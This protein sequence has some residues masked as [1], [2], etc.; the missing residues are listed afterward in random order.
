VL[1]HTVA[2]V[3]AEVARTPARTAKVAQLATLLSS[4]DQP[5]VLVAWLSGDLTQRQIGVGWATL[6]D[7]PEPAG[8]ASV[9]I[10]EVEAAFNAIKEVSGP[11]SQTARREVIESLF[12]RATEV[13]QRFLR[14]LLSG[15]L[16]QGAL[17]GVVMAAI[18]KAS[19]VSLAELRRAAMLRGDLPAVAAAALS[20]GSRALR[21]FRLQVGRAIGPM[22]AQTA[23]DPAEAL[24]KLGG[25]AAFEWKLDGARVQLHRDGD[26]A[27]AEHCRH[28]PG[29]T[30]AGTDRR[31]RG[32][33]AALRR[34]PPPVPGDRVGTRRAANL[35]RVVRNDVRPVAR[36]W[37]RPDR[38][39][40]RG[41]TGRA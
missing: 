23:A 9:S 15:D 30:G 10:E 4:A 3:S 24:T 27:A 41:P 18:A 31:R 21:E 11:G 28:R 20:G 35:G 38:R 5:D 26:A 6:R 40:G 36:R 32:D 1:L 14:G 37:T 39:A 25:R 13:E 7:L 2:S 33:R 16:R 34:P 19:G 29:V 17:A 8:V 22:L 12:A